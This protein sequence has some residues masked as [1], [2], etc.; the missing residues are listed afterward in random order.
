MKKGIL[1]VILGMGI[2]GCAL[3]K[4]CP[5]FYVYSDSTG[6]WVMHVSESGDRSTVGQYNTPTD[7]DRIAQQLNTSAG[8]TCKK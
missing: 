2:V 4:S 5:H 1:A 3:P 6:A 7:A 8:N